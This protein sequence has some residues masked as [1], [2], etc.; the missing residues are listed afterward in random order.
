M[1]TPPWQTV[2]AGARLA[3]LDDILGSG[4]AGAFVRWRL[5][6]L[7]DVAVLRSPRAAAVPPT[8]ADAAF[9]G[10]LVLGILGRGRPTLVS[11]DAEDAILGA[12]GNTAGLRIEER[13]SGEPGAGRL[14]A[15][16]DDAEA[17]TEVAAAVLAAGDPRLKP[18]GARLVADDPWS[19]ALAQTWDSDEER[20]FFADHL[21]PLLGGAI[22]FLELQRPLATMGG[23]FPAG[24]DLH[25]ARVDFAL[26]AD[27]PGGR[28]RMVV[29]LDGAQHRTPNLAAADRQ[30]DDGLVRG[31]WPSP[32]RVSTDALRDANHADMLN[33]EG[34]VVGFPD[35]HP[36]L[37]RLA[38]GKPLPWG[39]SVVRGAVAILLTPLAVFRIQHALAWALCDGTL[40]LAVETWG[41]SVVERD[42]PCAA[43]AVADFL[44][45][46]RALCDLYG[47]PWRL[48]AVDLRVIDR[49]PARFASPDLGALPGWTR[50]AV[51]CHTVGARERLGPS[52]LAIDAAVL[53]PTTL[54]FADGPGRSLGT[55][56]AATRTAPRASDATTELAWPDPRPVTDAD[57]RAAELTHFLRVLYRKPSFRFNQDGIVKRAM[58]R[59]STIGLLPTG[60]GKSIAY[61]LPALL[62]PGLTLVIDPIKSL[63]LDQVDNLRAQGIDDA[64]FLNSD[65]TGPEKDAVLVRLR[66]GELRF[67][68]VSPERLQ[69]QEFR[70]VLAEVLHRRPIAFA[71]LDEAHC[72]SEWGHDFRTA[73]L[74]VGK[75]ARTLCARH[76]EPPPLLGLTGTASKT[77]LTDVQRELAIDDPEAIVSVASFDRPE[78]HF[79]V[80]ATP[81][82]AKR[83]RLV[84]WLREEVPAAF[85][86]DPSSFYDG[87]R[88]GIVFFPH[89][90]GDYGTFK[91]QRHIGNALNVLAP[92]N[93]TRVGH[94]SGKSPDRW[95][96]GVRTPIW[97]S[98][99]W[100]V[101]KRDAQRDF[102][103][104]RI[105]VLCATKAFGMGIDKPNIRFTV[106]YGMASSPEAFAQEAGR[107]G[108]DQRDARC[109]VIFSDDNVGQAESDDPIQPGI[110]V[111]EARRRLH[112]RTDA[113][114]P[115]DDADRM[116]F[117]HTLGYAG[118]D[119]EAAAVAR[120][121]DRWIA[122][123]LAKA[124]TEEVDVLLSARA[125]RDDLRRHRATAR[126]PGP[127]ATPDDEAEGD[128]Q[129]PSLDIER[130]VYRL[131]LV[132]IVR[133]YTIAYAESGHAADGD[134]ALAERFRLTV[135]RPNRE[136]VER[137]VLE[138]VGRYRASDALAGV[139][140]GLAGGDEGFVERA[141]LALCRFIYDEVEK[142]R[143]AAIWTMRQILRQSLQRADAGAE[144]RRQLAA[145][146]SDSTFTK[147]VAD[148]VGR[149]DAPSAGIAAAAASREEA[150]Q[151]FGQAQRYIP[152]DPENPALYGLSGLA[153][154]LMGDPEAALRDL[155]TATDLAR[156]TRGH[157][158][159][160][161]DLRVR[162]GT[163]AN[164]RLAGADGVVGV[165][166][167]VRRGLRSDRREAFARA[168]HPVVKGMDIDLE[169]ACAAVIL[170]SMAQ[171]VTPFLARQFGSAAR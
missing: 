169:R 145:Y 110:E 48:R 64:A 116:L 20:R 168:A 5:A 37:Q 109:L 90:N 97:S 119:M 148:L 170:R 107:A 105:A 82:R 50:A 70:D 26:D 157:A 18:P 121:F 89:V 29:E 51:R 165:A 41:L 135:V 46:A 15:V 74:N 150:R 31:G 131:S 44:A 93:G 123:E 166:D 42:V 60:A 6:Q 68:F 140:A 95:I 106:H 69:I 87:S 25:A 9:V 3:A 138:Y 22:G 80:A 134:D 154:A 81:S 83:S 7:C 49:T 92:D 73:Y 141:I 84:Q 113:G 153:L 52:D 151:L 103:A 76:G 39:D 139:R 158:A 144:L 28:A 56:W 122:P 124:G 33:L 14:R 34:A 156:R 35:A 24:A 136:A 54:V 38:N 143:R 126:P 112:A 118:V 59:K 146:L 21:V 32:L 78:L 63:M 98:A 85:A 130:V 132:G 99:A 86:A 100:A 142:Q 62:S 149:R 101:H 4:E 58:A 115:A 79:Q 163:L 67:L 47:I 161:D 167:L 45:H 127:R 147:A 2:R 16:S 65:L 162:L 71:V 128:G 91:N 129:S 40:A 104:N 61:Q 1:P 111:E 19:V 160:I 13:A 75:H 57:A 55:A 27:V 171:D 155:G 53:A 72:V 30:R 117:L 8:S 88:G 10:R 114:L 133:D 164:H 94:Y 12:L 17:W 11:P 66:A 23:R 152:S 125:A 36:H 120:V 102:K 108:R 96:D 77:V 43:L 159:A 137:A